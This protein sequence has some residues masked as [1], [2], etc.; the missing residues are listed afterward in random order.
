MYVN[1][2][3]PDGYL[4]KVQIGDTYRAEQKG[5]YTVTYLVFDESSNMTLVSYQVTVK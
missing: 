4:H 3:S 5:T 1:V 2:T